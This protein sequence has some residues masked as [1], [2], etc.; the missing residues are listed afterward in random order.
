MLKYIIISIV[1]LL[2]VGVGIGLLFIIPST[3]NSNNSNNSDIKNK[4]QLAANCTFEPDNTV[5]SVCEKGYL[6]MD[7]PRTKCCPKIDGCSSGWYGKQNATS[8]D[9]GC[10]Q[11]D[12]DHI[13]YCNTYNTECECTACNE[14]YDFMN[15]DHTK[16]CP[17]LDNSMEYNSKCEVKV[18]KKGYDFMGQLPSKCCPKIDG[19]I[20]GWYGTKNA[21]SEDCGCAKCLPDHIP[22]CNAY[23][24]E[25]EC[26]ACDQGYDFM[27][28]LPSKCCPKIDGCITGWYGTKNAT[29]EDCGCAMCLPDHIPNC[30]AYNTECECT[31]YGV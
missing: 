24:T 18:C 26:T 23:N 14:G 21:T 10:G 9:C 2:L 4:L 20:T 16:C 29:S 12:K 11:C 13:Q 5:C 25:C 15:E 31:Q 6:F 27:R 22:N 30:K 8:E 1:V 7:G 19:C 17:K 28:Q 3:N